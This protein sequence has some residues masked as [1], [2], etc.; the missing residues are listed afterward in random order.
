MVKHIFV[1]FYGRTGS[2]FIMQI[3]KCCKQCK[4]L[5][6]YG[7]VFT[8]AKAI[9]KTYDAQSKVDVLEEKYQKWAFQNPKQYLQFVDDSL[10][11]CNDNYLFSKIQIAYILGKNSKIS[12][13]KISQNIEHI[14]NFKD[15]SFVIIKRD[16]IDSYISLQKSKLVGKM[17][18]VDTTAYK[19]EVN[20]D[21]FMKYF[22][23]V[24]S[25]YYRIENLLKEMNK[26]F[27]ILKYEDVIG[28][29]DSTQHIINK[30]KQ[31]GL[32]LEA[33]QNKV[34]DERFVFK[35]DRSKKLQDKI[36]N[37]D[38]FKKYLCSK[39]FGHLLVNH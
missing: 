23:E 3:L 20:S 18:M 11:S 32:D 4:V 2:T 36:T 15:A 16:I 6:G 33:D 14:L 22:T 17:S 34:K 38:S 25:S 37:Y 24:Q 31:I 21:D 27:T 19:I 35:Q 39:G 28:A 8:S 30:M 1:L 13:E 7:E 29:K 12:E 5:C 9:M 26:Q 10:Q